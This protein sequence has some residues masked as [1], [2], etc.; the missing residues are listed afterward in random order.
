ML[1]HLIIGRSALRASK[2]DLSEY[3]RVSCTLVRMKRRCGVFSNFIVSQF[4]KLRG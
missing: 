2:P 1:S 3:A 4:G